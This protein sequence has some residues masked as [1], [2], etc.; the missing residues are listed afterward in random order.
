LPDLDKKMSLFDDPL[1]LLIVGAIVIVFIMW[2]PKK[3]P[4]LARALG[5]ARGEFTAGAAQKPVGLSE[6]ATSFASVA[7]PTPQTVPAQQQSA[8]TSAGA[9]SVAPSAGGDNSDLV[10]TA[11]K[12]GIPTEGRT[13]AEISDAIVAK[14]KGQS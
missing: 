9:V 3:I 6:L 12:L 8:S 4:E 5:Q 2:G 13:P 7:S 10:G 14:V 11:L 1:Q